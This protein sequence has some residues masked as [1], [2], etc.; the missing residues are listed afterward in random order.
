VPASVRRAA[1]GNGRPMPPMRP[2]PWK[3]IHCGHEWLCRARKGDTNC[4]RCGERNPI[5]RAVIATA[6][7]ETARKPDTTPFALLSASVAR[8]RPA[9]APPLNA[10]PNRSNPW[11][12]ADTPDALPN[13]LS[14]IQR[15]ASGLSEARRNQGQGDRSKRT[16][17]PRTPVNPFISQPASVP[18]VSRK[19]GTFA[20]LVEV[21]CGC[22][23]GWDDLATIPQHVECDQHGRGAVGAT[24]DPAMR[25]GRRLTLA[26]P[27]D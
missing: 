18:P 3:C 15:A 26:V 10:G 23:Y 27:A 2:F 16:E 4:G 14:V 22:S 21:S 6:M 25:P 12:P 7:V 5:P 19:V 11:G 20:L 9:D 17:A 13:A 8:I 1:M 24:F